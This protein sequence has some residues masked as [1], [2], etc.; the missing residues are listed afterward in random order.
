[1][2]QPEIIGT[3]HY[4]TAQRIKETLQKYKEL[5]DI[6]AILGIDELSEEDRLTVARACKVE[7]FLAQPFFVAE[8]FTGS[9]GKYVSLEDTIKGFTM[10]L[11]GELDDLPEQSFYLVENID[12]AIA[13][14]ETLK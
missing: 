6:I 10:V 5:Q 3:E 8:I 7:R 9:P 1:M 12:E 13:K 2:L 11:T 14:A 4:G